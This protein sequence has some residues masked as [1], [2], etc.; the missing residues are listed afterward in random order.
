MSY[1][2]LYVSGFLSTL[3]SSKYNTIIGWSFLCDI[4]NICGTDIAKHAA[5]L[6]RGVHA[7]SLR[8]SQGYRVE[9]LPNLYPFL[10]YFLLLSQPF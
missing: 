6:Q 5:R 1:L 9:R 2:F 3:G 8:N 7:S 10:P 4:N